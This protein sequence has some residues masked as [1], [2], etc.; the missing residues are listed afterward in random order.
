MGEG[1][2]RSLP[3]RLV[4]LDHHA[5][6]RKRLTITE[7]DFWPASFASRLKAHRCPPAGKRAT[8]FVNARKTVESFNPHIAGSTP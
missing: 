8:G 6:Q 7:I 4:G 5:G 1:G 3:W 2:G